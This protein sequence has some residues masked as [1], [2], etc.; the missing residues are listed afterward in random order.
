[1]AITRS[2]T[3][4]ARKAAAR[5]K[6][7]QAI[8][9]N[10][11]FKAMAVDHVIGNY[12]REQYESLDNYYQRELQRKDQTNLILRDRIEAL[13]F[14]AAQARHRDHLNM[15]VINMSNSRIRS[16]EDEVR[17]MDGFVQEVYTQHPEIAW[18]YRNRLQYDSIQLQDPEATEVESVG[19]P[20][21]YAHLFEDSEEEAERQMQ[22]R[23]EEDGYF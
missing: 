21:E 19:I 5:S 11:T 17:F 7:I 2:Q 9:N 16:L 22:E 3:N 4:N 10:T 8:G 18:E 12:Y 14:D 15:N 1:M 20:E 23:M 13:E 6:K